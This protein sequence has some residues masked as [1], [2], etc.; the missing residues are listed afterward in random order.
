MSIPG[1]SSKQWSEAS[2][3]DIEKTPIN[4]HLKPFKHHFTIIQTSFNHHLA[5]I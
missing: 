5:N 1:P 3:G 2:H 4:H